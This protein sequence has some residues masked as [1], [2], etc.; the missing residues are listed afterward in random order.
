VHPDGEISLK[1][2][3]DVSSQTGK[4]TIGNIDQP[5]ISQRKVEQ[6]IR[7]RR[8]EVNLLGGILEESET[9]STSGTPFLAQIPI[10][11]YLFS[12]NDKEKHTTKWCSCWC[13]ISSADR[14]FQA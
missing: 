1:V 7:L 9:A 8:R 14:N 4:A 5:I 12:N 3:L 13:R 10:L 6:E 2:Q 11:K